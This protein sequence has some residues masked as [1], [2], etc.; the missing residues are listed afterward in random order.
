[1]NGGA[2]AIFLFPIPLQYCLA[3]IQSL[4]GSWLRWQG[5]VQD[6]SKLLDFHKERRNTWTSRWFFD[7]HDIFM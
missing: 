2:M 6:V 5:A 7:N 3:P 1:M 4:G